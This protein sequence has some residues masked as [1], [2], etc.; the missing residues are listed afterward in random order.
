MKSLFLKTRIAPEIMRR[1][2][3]LSRR[4]KLNPSV[5]L[6]TAV[7]S[8]LKNAG[9]QIADYF[10]E[11]ERKGDFDQW[12]KKRAIGK[13]GQL[14]PTLIVRVPEGMKLAFDDFAAKRN[15]ASPE[16]LKLVV[17]KLV[18]NVTLD[19]NDADLGVEEPEPRSERITLRFSKKEVA[20]LEPLA[21][22]FGNIRAWLVSLARSKI[23]QGKPQF[24]QQEV[25]ALYESCRE[26]WAVG[27]NINQIAHALNQDMKQAGRIEGSVSR[28]AELDGLKSVIKQHTEKVIGL[29]NA[30]MNRWGE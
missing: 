18:A 16:L 12:A 4:N 15:M 17:G 14:N 26:L 1:F 24:S 25:K 2:V 7:A 19:E 22:D 6:R 30:S 20:A 5:T 10:P 29:C 9:Y 28:L 11:K 13:S 8:M 21:S 23:N 27:R 3:S